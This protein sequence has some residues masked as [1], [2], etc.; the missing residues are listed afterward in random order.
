I[1]LLG[2]MQ[3]PGDLRRVIAEET[4]VYTMA[5]PPKFF[6]KGSIGQ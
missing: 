4:E 3:V 2:L 5:A 1:R 6:G